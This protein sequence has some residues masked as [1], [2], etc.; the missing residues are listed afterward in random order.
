MRNDE[1][2]CREAMRYSWL[3]VEFAIIVV[4]FAAGGYWL[5]ITLQTVPGFTAVLGVTGL[6]CALYRAIRDGMQFRKWLTEHRKNLDHSES[7][8]GSG[9][10]GDASK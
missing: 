5:D 3:G 4:A 7:D 9:A 2:E 8:S 10:T 1:T 6:I